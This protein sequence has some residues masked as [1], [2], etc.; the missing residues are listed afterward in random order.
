MGR[1]EGRGTRLAE[2]IKEAE[3]LILKVKAPFQI[4]SDFLENADTVFNQEVLH[5]HVSD[6]ET[7]PA[8]QSHQMK[9]TLRCVN[10]TQ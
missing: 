3:L 6:S 5:P 7:I 8:S 9:D 10:F 2:R 4:T 1:G